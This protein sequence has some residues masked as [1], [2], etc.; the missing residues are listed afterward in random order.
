[1]LATERAVFEEH[2]VDCA[3]CQE[4]LDIARSLRQAVRESIA[5]T[6]GH[7]SV[8]EQSRERRVAW[9][10]WRWAA[11]TA[12]AVLLI[13]VAT[14][15]VFLLHRDRARRQLVTARLSLENPPAVFRLSL[16]R[17]AA[18]PRDIAIPG[19]QRWMVFL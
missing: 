14:S 11:I 16:S 19:G 3:E 4:Q 13:A 6:S 2:F 17:D 9:T 15:T 12:C 10:G 5:E 18:E 7:W 8:N 1:M